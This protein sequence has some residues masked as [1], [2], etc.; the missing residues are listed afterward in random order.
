M[1]EK[2]LST[3][4]RAKAMGEHVPQCRNDIV[5][6]LPDTQP[7]NEIVMAQSTVDQEQYWTGIVLSVGPGKPDAGQR[8]DLDLEVGSRVVYR[9]RGRTEVPWAGTMVILITDNFVFAVLPS[10]PEIPNEVG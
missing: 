4:E 10:E 5:A 1:A 6:I 9:N 7:Q 3:L 2:E 8:V